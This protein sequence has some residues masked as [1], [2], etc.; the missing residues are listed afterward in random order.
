MPVTG[1]GHKDTHGMINGLT[2][3]FDGWVYCNHGYAND[4][5]ATG[6]DSSV[7]R[8]NSGN[9]FRM[10]PDGSHVEI[11]CTRGQV[12]PF[13]QCMDE[14]GNHYTSDCHSRAITQLIP[15]AVYSSFSQ[16]ARRPRVRT[17]HGSLVSRLPPPLTACV[18]TGP[19]GFR[20]IIAT[21]F[22]SAKWSTTESTSSP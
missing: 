12:N 20:S 15:G 11:V 21:A 19:T 3:G 17:G 14:F 4:S 7:V 22:S 16:A 1:F 8:M 10:K 6:T 5:V 2:L 18:I 13:G 9:V